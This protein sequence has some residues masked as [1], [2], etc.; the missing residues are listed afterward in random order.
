MQFL[1]P[2]AGRSPHFPAEEFFFPKSLVEVLGKPMIQHVVEN[3]FSIDKGSR[4][5]FVVP[6]EGVRR[7]SM[8]ST[9]KLIGGENCV[10][11]Q[12]RGRTRGALCSALMAIDSI[13]LDQPIIIANG[14][15]IID[16]DLKGVVEL[17]RAR[18]ANAGVI[19]FDSVHPRWS[20]VETGEESRVLQAAEKKVISNKAIAGF[21]YF[22]TGSTFV[23]A[24]MR[25]IEHNTTVDGGFYTAPCLNEVI[26]NGGLVTSASIDADE[27]HS[28]H[29]PEMIARFERSERA[30]RFLAKPTASNSQLKVVIPAAGEGARFR[31]AGFSKPKPFI[32][33]LGQPMIQHVLEN[34]TPKNASVHLLLRREHA[35][36]EQ[37][38]VGDLVSREINV[39]YV[40]HL[41]EGTACTLLLAREAFDNQDPLLVANSD[42]LVDFSVD[43]FVAD[44][45]R[46]RLD[47]S[48]LVFREK[49]LDSKWSYARLDGDG[50]VVEVA[51]KKAI[52]DL[53][54]VG[55][56]SFRRG[57]DFVD[58]A[59]DMI[60]RND[61]VNNE[62][63]TCPVYNYLVAKGKR[64][65]VYEVPRES[66]HGLGTPEDL[67][68]FVN[69]QASN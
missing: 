6:E 32:D 69:R 2:L 66:M 65:G 33:V 12:L 27:Y 15:Q 47:G 7:F 38:L 45:M 35:D 19:I 22:D 9:L 34:I 48:I 17:F 31:K 62:F 46:R 24:A 57:S 56:Y 51:E 43:D 40:N 10:V 25:C 11:V 3:L 30:R 67:D 54:T 61:R 26:L 50:C 29:A 16:A 28:F 53:A 8:E 58:G 60:V 1:I 55:I 68:V 14:D 36:R 64:I 5:I 49:S 13:D 44:C 41:T 18:S 23:S 59:I 37:R 39:H 20:Y 21:Y 42:Q 4:L 63:Y 52:S